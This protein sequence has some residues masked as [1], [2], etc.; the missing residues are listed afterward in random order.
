MLILLPNVLA[1]AVDV[2]CFLPPILHEIMLTLDGLIAESE[3]GARSYLNRYKTKKRA[4]LMPVALLSGEKSDLDFLL[5]PI[6]KGEIWGLISDAGLP[7]LADPGAQLVLRARYHGIKVRAISGPSS[8]TLALMQ[9]GLSGQRFSFHGYI[10]KEGEQRKKELL[11][12]QRLAQEE[13]ATQIFI[14]APYRNKHTYLDCLK[15]LHPKTMLCIA[16]NLTA[17]D[18]IIITLPVEKHDTALAEKIAKKP[19][20]FLFA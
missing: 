13:R 14:E 3:G 18:E 5:E 16:S 4:H 17:E 9:S 1:S 20:L 7:C 10:A 19:T 8:I 12:W 2:A 11:A 6:R 15:Y